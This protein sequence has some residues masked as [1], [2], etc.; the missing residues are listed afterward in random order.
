[1]P[2]RG[3]CSSFPNFNLQGGEGG[4]G[5]GVGSHLVPESSDSERR[6]RQRPTTELLEATTTAR[7]GTTTEV[8]EKIPDFGQG[9]ERRRPTEVRFSFL[10]FFRSS[11]LEISMSQ[12]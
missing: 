9:L 5:W 7:L 1:M 2:K 11:F 6:R 10:L 4:G 3:T 8:Q 12:I